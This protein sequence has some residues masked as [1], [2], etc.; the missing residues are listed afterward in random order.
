MKDNI[1]DSIPDI[2]SPS[3]SIADAIQSSDFLQ[4][5]LIDNSVNSLIYRIELDDGTSIAVKT[6]NFQGTYDHEENTEL[7]EE[8]ERWE[9]FHT[10]AHIVGLYDYGETDDNQTWIAMEHMDGG[11]LEDQFR[12]NSLKSLQQGMWIIKSIAAGLKVAHKHGMAHRDLKPQ[13]IMFRSVTDG[14]DVPKIGDW[15]TA[16]LLLENQTAGDFTD[17]WAAPEQHKHTVDTEYLKQIDIFQLGMIMYRV[18]TG[19]HPFSKGLEWVYKRDE[20]AD[21]LDQPSEI[22]PGIPSELDRL[23]MKCMAYEPADRLEDASVIYRELDS[24]I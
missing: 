15:G 16:A 8:A 20:Y 2:E 13:N 14:W 24:Y 1:P 23:I 11:T 4:D 6:P 5:N 18:L 7:L 12:T 19:E 21:K 17:Y 22:R 10:H 9:N 3:Q